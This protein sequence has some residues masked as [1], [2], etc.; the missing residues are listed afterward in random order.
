MPS[1]LEGKAALV[2]GAASGIGRAI[3]AEFARD[4]AR[5]AVVDVDA[6][7][8]T[9][10]ADEIGGSAIGIGADVADLDQIDAAITEAVRT[11]GKLDVLVN[12]AGVFDQNAPCEE[13]TVEMWDHLMSINVRGTAFVMQ[14]A[15]REMLPREAGSII[16]LSSISALVSGGGGAAYAASK[17]AI[18]SLTRQVAREVGS[19]GVR[20]NALAPGAIAT[21]LFDNTAAILGTANPSGPLAAQFKAHMAGRAGEIPLGIG[22]GTDVAPVAAFLASDDARYVTGHILVVDGGATA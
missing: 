15:L 20:V 6:T 4:G 17:G 1:R 14:R 5:V 9:A 18:L 16:N 3:A 7:G 12:N 11:L 22:D 2:T 8:A 21:N 13:L 10:V 19:R